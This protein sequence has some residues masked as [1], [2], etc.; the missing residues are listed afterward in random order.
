[1]SKMRVSGK[2]LDSYE[3]GKFESIQCLKCKK[4]SW[5]QEDIK[6]IFCGSCG[7]HETGTYLLTKFR[8]KTEIIN[9]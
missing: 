1:M 3:K 9:N 4:T 2:K 7:Y 6:N 5:S 8:T